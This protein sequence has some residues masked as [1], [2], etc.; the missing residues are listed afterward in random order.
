M[1]EPGKPGGPR[2]SAIL[3]D[4]TVG[5][6]H[7]TD[8]R[9]DFV[10]EAFL[11][12]FG[13]RDKDVLGRSFIEVTA[14]ADRDLV[15][16]RYASL[17]AQDAGLPARYEREVRRP[18]GTLV[19]LEIE[20]R[21]LGE[22]RVLVSVRDVT[23]RVRDT[24]LLP[25][26]AE[27]AL[28]V[29][30]ERTIGS[31]LQVAATGLNALGLHLVIARRD[32]SRTVFEQ[33]SVVGAL[34][35]WLDQALGRRLTGMGFE[36]RRLRLLSQVERDRRVVFSD[37]S[38]PFLL[39]LCLAVKPDLDVA[40]LKEQLIAEGTGKCVV[41]P[42][43]VEGDLWGFFAAA[44]A[45]LT[46]ADAAALGLFASKVASA[47]EGAGFIAHLERR[48]R[49]LAAVQEVAEA[50]TESTLEGLLARL[51]KVTTSALGSE[52]EAIYLLDE[53]RSRLELAAVTEHARSVAERFRSFPLDIE[54]VAQT[55]VKLRPVAI[56]VEA[57]LPP[58]AREP[59]VRRGLRQIAVVPLHIK[60]RLAGALALARSERAFL[61]EELAS[62]ELL[63]GQMA[64]QI[65]NARLYADANRRLRLMSTLF[66]LA[67]I[68][69]STLEVKTLV[70]RV[71]A[72]AVSALSVDGGAIHVLEEGKLTLAGLQGEV[73]HSAE[74]IHELVCDKT[75]LLGRAVLERRTVFLDEAFFE[76]NPKARER[77]GGTCFAAM[78]PLVLQERV[79]GTLTVARRDSRPFDAEEGRLLEA[80]TAQITA[81]LEQA[82]SFEEERRRVEDFRL[83]LEVGRVV[84]GSLDLHQILDASAESLARIT[85]ASAA[86]ILL[87]DPGRRVL[88]GVATSVPGEAEHFRTVRISLDEPSI[89]AQAVLTGCPVRITDTQGL[90]MRRQALIDRHGHRSILALPLT[91]RDQAIGAVVIG[92]STR[93]REWTDAQI[94][95]ATVVARQVAVAVANARLYEDLKRSYDQ[96]ARAQEEL[97]KRERLAALGELSAV[98]AHEVR[99]PLGVIFNSLRSLRRVLTVEGDAAMLLDIVGEEADRLNRIVGDLLD[100]ARPSEPALQP[101]PLGAVLASVA[102]AAAPSAVASGVTIDLQ[103]EEPLPKPAVDARMLR[104]ALL[105]LVMNAV[106]AMPRGGIVTLRADEERRGGLARARIEVA[107][108]GPG[109]PPELAER[110]FEP[111]LTTKAT[112]PG[113]G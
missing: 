87:L 54:S 98:V 33:V 47:L 91:V 107:D 48:N 112:G 76:A 55:F 85:E 5:V 49:E 73:P 89:P 69:T 43:T 102:E 83:I 93:T 88:R 75:T 67:Q 97:V 58:A 11:R 21:H 25:A 28:R 8:E 23:G 78:A 45:R 22:R 7:A 32:G 53:K 106:Q 2:P 108:T 100:F 31:V 57:D 96:L 59:L 84:T 56:Q 63:A 29:Q 38:I 90:G 3:R 71:L 86:S 1:S 64:I 113:L 62:A 72:Q 74:S 13:L 101:E 20:P 99:N 36:A 81:A 37:D 14:P 80:L 30:R 39:D 16:Q 111:F 6:F 40:L 110:V 4:L 70:Q 34:G 95:R 104:Q 35:S 41:C 15:R 61:D 18:D 79:L 19:R 12:I 52:A 26:L 94:E 24:T 17:L 60:G 66:D 9:I 51:L 42:L 92:D 65:E 46:S 77:M 27:L 68:G 103:A 105:N 44:S 82:R 50:G 10:N 109:I